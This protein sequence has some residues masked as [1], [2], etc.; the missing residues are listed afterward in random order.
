MLNFF[1]ESQFIFEILTFKIYLIKT[2]HVKASSIIIST[3]RL[4]QKDHG[5]HACNYR[6]DRTTGE[7]D[8]QILQ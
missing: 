7:K 4:F 6:K 5:Q 1:F 2:K 8:K 3:N